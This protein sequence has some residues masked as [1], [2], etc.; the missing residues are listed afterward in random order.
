MPLIGTTWRTL[1]FCCA[2]AALTACGGGGSDGGGNSGSDGT[3]GTDGGGTGGDTGGSDS[4]TDSGSDTSGNGG[5]DTGGTSTTTTPELSYTV[6]STVSPIP[7]YDHLGIDQ[8]TY[9][10]SFDFQP[11][12]TIFVT[13]LDGKK[14]IF[15]FPTLFFLPT[16]LPGLEFVE[17]SP[18]VFSMSRF[19]DDVTMGNARD[20]KLFDVAD[21]TEKKFVV[22][23]HGSALQSGYQDW[24]FGYV[25][26]A[27]D[28]GSGF[29]FKKIDAI[30]SF[31]H[32]VAVGDLDKT[33]HDDIISVNMGVKS[34]DSY[35]SL[36]RFSQTSNDVFSERTLFA[37]NVESGSAGA[38]AIADLKGDGATQIIQGAQIVNA[39]YPE[40]EWGAIRIWSKQADGTFAV[41]ATLPREGNF[42]S[43]GATQITPVD[44]DNDGLI[45]LV[46]FLEGS[47]PGSNTQYDAT[48]LEIY[49]N[50]G[51]FNFTRITNQVLSQSMWQIS[52]FQARE[53]AVADVNN[54]GFKDIL[55]NG[56]NGSTL[57]QDNVLNAGSLILLNNAGK[58]FLNQK[59]AVGATVS[60][61]SLAD[62]PRFLRFVRVERQQA[63]FF[64]ISMS[65]APVII[66]IKVDQ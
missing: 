34:S 21:P 20:W 52:E 3:S 46:V 50:T 66:N 32:S 59:D 27:T 8:D 1:L 13:G 29:E 41:A 51:G 55:F 35:N 49:K 54:D 63:K 47:A 5:G 39:D 12:G 45:D 64:G 57:R 37:Q 62:Y 10:S 60:F 18:D 19:L 53:L 2:F 11:A 24:P 30:A 43:M 26:V 15:I 48:G 58:A 22:V 42:A 38:V 17:T 23:D 44:V 6:T 61:S 25:W 28:K 16:Q 4:G 65:G 7:Y 33:G 9:V 14:R 40:L 36:R 56:W 31:N